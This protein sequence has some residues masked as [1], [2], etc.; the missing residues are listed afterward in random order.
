MSGGVVDVADD[1]SGAGVGGV[2]DYGGPAAGESARDR[3]AGS[4]VPVGLE[5]AAGAGARG[6]KDAEARRGVKGRRVERKLAVRR[7]VRACERWL[8]GEGRRLVR[9]A[10]VG[11][12]EAVIAAWMEGYA[13]GA[14]EKGGRE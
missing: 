4:G 12:M 1:G 9:G 11:V 5:C 8:E 14:N 13:V 7:E 6:E 10:Y 2:V 3:R